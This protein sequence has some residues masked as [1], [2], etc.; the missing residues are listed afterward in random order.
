M[1]SAIRSSV[2]TKI[3]S[4]ALSS[5]ESSRLPLIERFPSLARIPRVALGVYPTPVAPLDTVHR[6]LWI[7][8]DDLSGDPLG[9]NKVR[10][11][12]FLLGPV[13]RGDRVVTVGSAGSTHAL[14]VATYGK[15]LGAHVLV[16]RWRQ[17]MNASAAAVAT[18]VDRVAER[19]RV[20]HSVIA[21]YAWAT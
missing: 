19:S 9:G 17:E 13:N 21:A 12:E 10:A 11:L 5:A 4:K 8:R 6:S 1:W 3:H 14:A 7:K 15:R 20:F 16:G 18:Q 2:R